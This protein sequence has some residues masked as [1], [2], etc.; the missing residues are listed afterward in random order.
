M[1]AIQSIES[2]IA[3]K[4]AGLSQAGFVVGVDRLWAPPR[5]WRADEDKIDKE[6]F[7]PQYLAAL[8]LL[9]WMFAAPHKA[10]AHLAAEMQAGKTGVICCLLRLILI[11]ENFAKIQIHEDDVFII[12]GMSDNSWKK[13]TRERV[14]RE[15]RANVQHNRG[16]GAV[17]A[18]MAR[19]AGRDAD[20][21]LKNVL[22]FL[23]ESHLAC[24]RDNRPAKEIFDEMHRLCP[25]ARWGELNVRLV[26]ISATDPAAVIGA[27]AAA[28]AQVINLRTSDAYQS[29]ETLQ[30]DGRIH[31]THNLVDTP[32]VDKMLAFIAA[33]Y[34]AD[35]A[36]FH[37]L[38][39]SRGKTTLVKAHLEAA[40]HDVIVWDCS[41][42]SARGKGKG[43]GSSS[44]ATLEDIN[45][46]LG[47]EPEKHTFVLLKNMFYAAKTL[48]DT[49]CGILHD[50][51]G[52][53][54]DTNLQSL[55]GRACGYGKSKRTH[56]FTSEAT[57]KTYL[58]VWT[59]IRPRDALR[60]PD[61]DPSKLH[62][63]MAGIGAR[64]VAG[65]AELYIR[66]Q[67]AMPMSGGGGGG[68][69]APAE[70]PR[71]QRLD[72]DAFESEWSEWFHT[73]KEALTWWKAHGGRGQKL[74]T[75]AEGFWICS[76][77]KGP[78]RI[79]MDKIDGWRTGKKTAG[80]P[81]PNKMAPGASQCRRYCAYAD[82]TDKSTAR[83]CVH[84]V[85]KI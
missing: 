23:D 49:Y 43:D 46:I 62:G 10:W 17:K 19:K 22:I 40:G 5:G 4:E 51:L 68:A 58:D 45:E 32:S 31:K 85:K 81:S 64:A 60:I 54:D 80:M 16:L 84:W 56:I 7:L 44:D 13:Q 36:L 42:S 15:F 66:Q 26:T 8:D 1:A 30:R 25:S 71:R 55:L 52:G 72:E 11:P 82:I 37:V 61:A 75:D 74:D 39:P 3:D 76:A 57:V 20:G 48:D 50:R 38:R 70:E 83:F 21:L 33:T 78:E 69:A 53:K 41:E 47:T 73:E 79:K 24:N 28:G 67:R 35:E 18:A 65:G 63:K 9:A 27:G 77:D 29:V 12:T 14:P 34:T 2:V 59:G 6:P